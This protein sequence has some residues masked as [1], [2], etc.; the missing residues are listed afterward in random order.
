MRMRP[1]LWLI[2]SFRSNLL[3]VLSSAS[4]HADISPYVQTS[5]AGIGL[6]QYDE[7]I[8][9]RYGTALTRIA[10]WLVSKQQPDGRWPIDHQEAPVDQ[11]EVM[12]TGGALMTL[13]A[14]RRAEAKPAYDQ[15]A[16]KAVTWLRRTTNGTT[17][18]LTFAVMGLKAGGV[19][20]DDVDVKRLIDMLRRRQ[21]SDGGWG[22]TESLGSNG[23]A[24]GQVLYTYKLAGVPIDDESFLRG[25]IWLLQHQS[26]DGSWQQINSQQTRSDRASNFATTMWAVIGLGAVFD[27]GTEQAFLSLIQPGRDR[28]Q[29]LPVLLFYLIPALIAFGLW[30]SRNPHAA[31]WPTR[32]GGKQ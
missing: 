5:L 16:Q 6:S 31:I 10:D 19:G 8:E 22:E 23:Y 21:K 4:S 20:D 11:G 12:V 32:R 17:Q 3:T 27:V 1:G 13:K 14:A 25:A 15:A 29:L 26:P 2:T 28:L 9:A 30:R 24:T 18:D 7:F